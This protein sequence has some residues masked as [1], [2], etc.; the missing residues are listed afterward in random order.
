MIQG[1]KIIRTI[2]SHL[3]QGYRTIIVTC[4]RHIKIHG[5]FFSFIRAVTQLWFVHTWTAV[6]LEHLANT[7]LVASIHGQAEPLAGSLSQVYSCLLWSTQYLTICS[8]SSCFALNPF[9]AYWWPSTSVQVNNMSALHHIHT[10]TRIYITSALLFIFFF[11]LIPLLLA[12]R[13]P[14]TLPARHRYIHCCVVVKGIRRHISNSYSCRR[15]CLSSFMNVL[16]MSALSSS[17]FTKSASVES[18]WG[19]EWCHLLDQLAFSSE[20][21]CDFG[22]QINSIGEAS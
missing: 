6:F 22:H 14:L 9:L 20:V 7:S 15:I 3:I 21:T 1:Y 12:G 17:C 2:D 4:K 5:K 18:L 16:V 10:D 11:T 13:L 8:N 19:S